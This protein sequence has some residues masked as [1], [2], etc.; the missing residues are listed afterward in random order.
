MLCCFL[1]V[2]NVS[3]IIVDEEVIKCRVCLRAI[4]HMW[5]TGDKLRKRCQAAELEQSDVCHLSRVQS[6]AIEKLVQDTCKT[7]PR[8]YQAI[9]S[10]EFD[11]VLHDNPKHTDEVA[12]AI[13]SACE[14]WVHNANSVAE[15]ALYVYSNLDS[16]KTTE[17]ILYPL[18]QRF[19]RVPCNMAKKPPRKW[20]SATHSTERHED[21]SRVLER[22]SRSASQSQSQ[23][24]TLPPKSKDKGYTKDEL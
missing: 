8:T 5:M 12:A 3:A 9:E 16:Q 6:G 18:Q 10:S 1:V 4:E 20:R 14:T 21:Y 19:C 17:E 11:L 23:S 24:H 13:Q 15:V 22:D 2:T 7:L